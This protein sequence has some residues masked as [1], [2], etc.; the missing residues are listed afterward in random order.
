MGTEPSIS[1]PN[2]VTLSASEIQLYSAFLSGELTDLGEN[3]E[4]NMQVSRYGFIY[5]TNFS[6]KNT[7]VLGASGIENTNLGS[8]SNV[9]QFSNRLTGLNENTTYYYRAYASNNLGLNLGE[10]RSFTTD[11]LHATFSLNGAIDGEQSGM[12][13]P[14]GSHTYNVTL[15][16]THAYNL[17]VDATNTVLDNIAI[18]E[19]T[20][21]NELYIQSA[22]FSITT[23]GF[24]GL[25]NVTTTFSG[26]NSGRR[27]LVLPLTTTDHHLVI[28]NGNAEAEN[29]TLTIAK[30]VGTEDQPIGRLL[31]DETPMGF[32]TNN[33]PELY[34]VHIPSNRTNFGVI[35]SGNDGNTIIC[36]ISISNDSTFPDSSGY[37]HIDFSQSGYSILRILNAEGAVD[38][39][40][41]QFKFRVTNQ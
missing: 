13:Y 35:L 32:F 25:S 19:G 31:I 40:G 11:I 29:Y 3:S 22:P 16:N 24:L 23:A 2:V 5:G 9:G 4:G 41:C 6:N 36:G 7:L 39:R 15:S 21:T 27:Y 12:I 28:S 34:W 37:A 38:Y 18:Y 8:R 30:E 17:S 20:N 26:T 10:I 1:L 33:D 14:G